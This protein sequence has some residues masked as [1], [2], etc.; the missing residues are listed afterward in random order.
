MWA[1]QPVTDPDTPW[2]IATGRYI[3]AHHV[4]PTTD[5]FSWSMRGHPWVTQ[6]WLFEIILAWLVNHLQFIGAWL[7]LVGIHSLTVIVLY[8]TCIRASRGNRVIAAIVASLGMVI[9]LPFWIYRPQVVSYLMFVVFLWILQKVRD[10]D[11][12][13]LWLVPPLLL[14]WTNAHGSACIGLIM[15]LLEVALSFLPSIGRLQTFKL[16]PTARWRMLAAATVGFG[17]GLLNPNGIKAYTYA[18]LSANAEMTNNITE[19]LSPNFHNAV[20]SG[21]FSALCAVLFPHSVGAPPQPSPARNLVLRGCLA[22]TLI[23][24]RMVPY[25]AIA[26]APLL[27]YALPDVFRS[28]LNLPR[29]IQIINGVLVFAAL[30]YVG[31]QLPSLRGSFSSHLSSSSYPIQAVNFL[32]KHHMTHLKLLNLYQWGGYLIYRGVPPFIDGRTDIYLENNTFSNY[33]AMQN[34]NWNG[35]SLITSYKFDVALFAPGNNIVTFLQNDPQWTVAYSDATAEILVKR[36][37]RAAKLSEN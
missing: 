31:G 28:L 29:L 10:G 12:R 25:A 2:H 7:L 1:A 21:R 37:T 3:L 17:L 5:P 9:A 34:V 20:L 22:I 15:L 30:F 27:A 19:W 13:V 11:L 33:L 8:Q 24:Q 16:S 6:E 26:A 14:V 32:E 4:I 18:L 23:H 36:G 35:P